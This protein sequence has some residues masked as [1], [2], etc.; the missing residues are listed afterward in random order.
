[1]ALFETV[2]LRE[3][4]PLFLSEHLLNLG[5]A[6]KAR[7]FDA[8]LAESLGPQIA[9]LTSGAGNGIIRLY[10]TAGDGAVASPVRTPQLLLLWEPQALPTKDCYQLDIHPLSHQ[11]LFGGLKTAN[12]WAHADALSTA[13]A[14][15]ADEALLLAH[16]GTLISACMANVFVLLGNELHTPG[17]ECGARRGIVRQWVCTHR[18]VQLSRLSAAH[19]EAA[20]EIFL[21]NSRIGIMPVSRVAKRSLGPRLFSTQLRR[22]YE[23][24]ISSAETP[25]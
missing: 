7:G 12:Y 20:D 25:S 3:G 16:D 22:E 2:A 5:E 14:N 21:T 15:G 11:P 18:Y 23:D 4:K 13:L 10:L 9:R 17:D 8:M 24:F 19:L 1:M 6:C